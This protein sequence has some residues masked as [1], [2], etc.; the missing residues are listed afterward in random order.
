MKVTVTEKV[1]KQQGAELVFDH[2]ND[3]ELHTTKHT[4]EQPYFALNTVLN[5]FRKHIL[6]YGDDFVTEEEL[7]FDDELVAKLTPCFTING[8]TFVSPHAWYL[9]YLRNGDETTISSVGVTQ[10]FKL[11]ITQEEVRDILVQNF[12]DSFPEVIF[13]KL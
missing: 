12:I 6:W 7:Y 8:E 2:S 4:K 1:Y 9:C 13:N 3:Y 11:I 10:Q 5:D